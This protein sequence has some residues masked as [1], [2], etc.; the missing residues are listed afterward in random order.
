MVLFWHHQSVELQ[1]GEEIHGRRL[2][3][4]KRLMEKI[5]FSY[6]LLIVETELLY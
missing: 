4:I 3:H 1:S 5:N 6:I 2:L